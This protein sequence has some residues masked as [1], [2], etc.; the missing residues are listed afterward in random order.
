MYG[1]SIKNMYDSLGP[2]GFTHKVYQLLGLEDPQSGQRRFN[3]LLGRNVLESAAIKPDSLSLQALAM[4]VMGL[5]AETLLKR[6]L[7]PHEE[8]NVLEAAGTAAVEPS[9]FANISVFNSVAAGMFEAKMLEAYQK[10]EYIAEQLFQ[11]IP[12]NKRSEKLIGIAG[13]G[14]SAEERKPG[15]RHPRVSLSE[16]YSTTPETTNFANGVDVTV[17]A[18]LF[19]MTKDVM[20]QAEAASDSLALRREFRCIDVFLGIV[21]TY[22]YGGTSYNT[23]LT[24]GN[25]VNDVQR[26]LVDW[27]DIDAVLQ[28]FT[29]MTDQENGLPIAI[30]PKDMFV[31]PRNFLNSKGILNYTGIERHTGTGAEVGL[32][33]NPIQGVLNLVGNPTYPYAYRRARAAD[34]LNYSVDNAAGLWFAGDFKKAFGYSQNIPFTVEKINGEGYE[35]KDRRLIFSMFCDEMGV[36]FVQ[37]PRF[38]V[39]AR[40]QGP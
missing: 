38:V 22:N 9:T 15:H 37:D 7:L 10:P 24:A 17:E 30:T 5:E 34:G 39:R 4:G 2:A 25:W 29:E 20:K 32:G 19:D 13:T 40:V 21:N 23:Y 11:V 33:S 18:V 35:S 31:M 6:G 1:V 8:I 36:P 14:D 16:R 28:L 27:R 26:P 3:P 12:S